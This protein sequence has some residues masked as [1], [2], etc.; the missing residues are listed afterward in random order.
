MKMNRCIKAGLDY[1]VPCLLAIVIVVIPLNV[2]A[3]FMVRFIDPNDNGLFFIMWGSG[4]TIIFLIMALIGFIIGFMVEYKK[5]I[6]L[7]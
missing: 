7:T 6:P 4:F 2:I 1:V 5:K 3:Y